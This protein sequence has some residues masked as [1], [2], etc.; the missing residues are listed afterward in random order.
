M[1]FKLEV[2]GSEG[3]ARLW[4]WSIALRSQVQ[5]PGGDCWGWAG[6]MHCSLVNNRQWHEKRSRRSR[7]RSYRGLWMVSRSSYVTLITKGK[8]WKGLNKNKYPL[9]SHCMSPT[10]HLL[11]IRALQA[12]AESEAQRCV[13]HTPKFCFF[14]ICD[15]IKTK[16]WW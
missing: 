2:K 12:S 13:L 11:R 15:S 7:A 16:L 4:F 14:I 1:P 6:P 5:M 8:H 9:T 10:H 3:G